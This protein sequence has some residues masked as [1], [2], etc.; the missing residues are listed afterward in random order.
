MHTY[1]VE[2]NHL[3]QPAFK[4]G[5]V[6]IGSLVR[7][8]ESGG[9]RGRSV[10]EAD[11]CFIPWKWKNS[12]IFREFNYIACRFI[13]HG[14]RAMTGYE[15]SD[16]LNGVISNQLANQAIFI[17]VVSAYLVAAYAVGKRLT[18]YQVWFVNFT[19]ILFVL[20]GLAGTAEMT[21]LFYEYS[22]LRT[23]LTSGGASKEPKHHIALWT[24]AGVRLVLVSGAL[25]FMWQV[26]RSETN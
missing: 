1:A 16:L 8:T 4:R 3:R 24:V 25:I 21:H 12:R 13:Q 17:T 11:V 15:A 26:R 19:F 5:G 18:K 10:P 20:I 9:F 7:G 14:G 2:P 22:A 6:H 23:E